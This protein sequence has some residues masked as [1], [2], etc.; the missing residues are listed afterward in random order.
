MH[1]RWSAKG[2]HHRRGQP[3]SGA[4]HAHDHARRRKRPLRRLSLRGRSPPRDALR[5][6]HPGPRAHRDRPYTPDSRAMASIGHPVVGDTLYG[7]AGQ[8]DGSDRHASRSIASRHVETPPETLSLDAIFCTRPSSSSLTP[9][10]A[11]RSARGPSSAELRRFLIAL[12]QMRPALKPVNCS[13]PVAQVLASADR[14]H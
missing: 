6:I 8:L 11:N 3:R 9:S 1:G 10:P 5:Q 7:G 12:E 13:V 2:H 14:S 4:A